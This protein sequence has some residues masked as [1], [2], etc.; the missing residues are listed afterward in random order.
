MIAPEEQFLLFSTI[1]CYLMLDFYVLNKDQ[2][3]STRSAVI[4]DNRSRDNESRL[5]LNFHISHMEGKL[6]VGIKH[7]FLSMFYVRVSFHITY[8]I[9][10]T[11]K[12][13]NN[14]KHRKQQQADLNQKSHLGI[15]DGH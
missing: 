9:S 1:F 2:I 13:T 10:I 4:R 5:Y 11:D 15:W 7:L 6:Q 14:A 3:F 8:N 12:A